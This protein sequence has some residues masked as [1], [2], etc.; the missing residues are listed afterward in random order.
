MNS[1]APG[2]M[3]DSAAKSGNRQHPAFMADSYAAR[4]LAPAPRNQLRCGAPTKGIIQA[5]FR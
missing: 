2:A 3:D 1:F 4:R 5:V